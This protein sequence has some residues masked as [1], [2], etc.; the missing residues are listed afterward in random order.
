MGTCNKPQIQSFG[1]RIVWPT[2]NMLLWNSPS[3]SSN[4][5]VEA[6]CRVEPKTLNTKAAQLS[7]NNHALHTSWHHS[8]YFLCQV[9]DKEV[10]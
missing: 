4:G 6:V 2:Y 3:M 9:L 1:K 8:V 5:L 7:G 10:G